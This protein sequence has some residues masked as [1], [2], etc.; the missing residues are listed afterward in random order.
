VHC[1]RW[2][3][4]AIIAAAAVSAMPRMLPAQTA[5][6]T[7][8]R[9]EAASRDIKEQEAILTDRA[10]TP[11]Q[12]EEAARRLVSRSSKE[13]DDVLLRVL[14]EFG[15]R[16]GQI[17]V[18]R[19]LASDPTPEPAFIAPLSE[20]LGSGAVLTEAVA[21]AL[22]TFKGND[23][24]RQTL[25]N[26]ATNPTYLLDARVGII[27]AMGKLV[28]K[29][30]AGSLIEIV[31]SDDNARIR[32]GAR[33]ALAEMTGLPRGRDVQEWNQWWDQN[34]GKTEEQWSKDLL[35]YNA[36]AR[37]DLNKRLSKMMEDAAQHLRE[38]YRTAA[39]DAEKSKL[40]STYLQSDSEDIRLLGVRLVRDES[41]LFRAV[42]PA[43]FDQLKK[44]VGDS[45][46]SV[47]R[48]VAITLGTA[49][50]GAVEALLTQ[51]AQE[52]D[53]MVRQE[54]VLALGPSHDLRA[55]DPL[56]AAL[57][58]PIYEVARSAADALGALTGELRKPENAALAARVAAELGRRLDEL[59][60]TPSTTA[61]RRGLVYTMA[62]LGHPS[63]RERLQRLAG[64]AE[65]EEGIRKNAVR[66]LGMIG[67]P[68]SMLFITS[69]L[70]DR[71]KLVQ[72][73]ACKAMKTC[74]DNFGGAANTLRSR[75]GKEEPDP[76]VR[77][78]AWET[79]SALFKIAGEPELKYWNQ[80][81]TKDPD[82][83]RRLRVQE[84][85]ESRYADANAEDRLAAI[86]QD[87]GTQYLLLNQPEKSVE[88]TQQ[89][90]DY[91]DSR[92]AV[93]SVISP[94]VNQL[95]TAKLRTKKYAEAV[96]FAQDRI[97]RDP[98]TL[99]DMFGRMR[100]Q[101]NTLKMA[102]DFTGALEL[103]TQFKRIELKQYGGLVQQMENE[104][105]QLQS[106]GGRVYVRQ[107]RAYEHVARF[108][109]HVS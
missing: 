11:I 12:R 99:T 95:M 105:K 49:G 102:N 17:A 101:I 69:A 59:K 81:L 37:A 21:Q 34:K 84:E 42:P 41:A 85:L 47:R 77:S 72:V 82:P 32:D 44:M 109:F 71:S 61:L 31:N 78:A 64:P 73:E 10:S 67:N 79:L 106:T 29:A 8:S 76:D 52:R 23:A 58:D 20:Q 33:D 19:A 40:L 96:D 38:S 39:N 60:V 56:L 68:A 92:N 62:S 16:D 18:A 24:V 4:S 104:I 93:E 5:Q 107:Q 103:L 108:Q 22:V 36:S 25:V 91:Y 88:K 48:E 100:E 51:L 35:R 27:S 75:I 74:A 94:V 98:A 70:E 3:S 66:G 86:R 57:N 15:N 14:K 80:Y 6:P 43:V 45:A 9:E 89:T 26:Y 87:M 13:A 30:A 28:D 54:L 46:S 90:L 7:E 53:A 1:K 2:I 63:S 65:P 97:K 83:S 55:V 50:V